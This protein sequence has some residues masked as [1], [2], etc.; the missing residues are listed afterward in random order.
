VIA[1]EPSLARQLDLTD[2]Y[3]CADCNASFVRPN[4][5][6][7]IGFGLI[8]CALLGCLAYAALRLTGG[9]GRSESSPRLKKEQIPPPP[10]P[11]FR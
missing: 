11:A 7:S 5:L 6:R 3:R 8:F 10:P 4:L 9:S 2:S 1:G